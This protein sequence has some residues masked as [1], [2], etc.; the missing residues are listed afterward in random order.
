MTGYGRSELHQNDR[1][2][3]VEIRTVNH[4]YLDVRTHMSNAFVHKEDAMKKIIQQTLKRGRVDVSLTVDG[5]P[6]Q[7]KSLQVD[8]HLARQYIQQMKELQQAFDLDGDIHIDMLTRVPDIVEVT[9]QSEQDQTNMV[10]EILQL[11]QKTVREV[12]QMRLTEGQA[13]QVDLKQRIDQMKHQVNDLGDRREIVIIEYQERIK[14]RIETHLQHA[15]VYDESQLRQ[16]IALLA[17]KGDI[18]E[19]LTRLHS[20]FV[21][22]EEMLDEVEPVGR[23]LDFILQ[24]IHR[25]LNTIGSKSNDTKISATIVQLKS[26]TEKLKEQV[27]NVE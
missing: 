9:D 12:D 2:L 21:Q 5:P 20:H 13:L 25:E 6:L 8:W 17:E 26:D 24:E 11:V 27:Q 19:E 18:S 1:K 10:D 23:K 15:S 22:F 14:E 16:E 4:R 3:S 7:E